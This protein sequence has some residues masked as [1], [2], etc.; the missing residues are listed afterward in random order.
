MNTIPIAFLQEDFHSEVLDFL[1]ELVSKNYPNTQLIWYNNVDRYDNI[2][3]YK[4]KYPNLIVK[5][6]DEFIPNLVDDVFHKCFIISYDNIINVNFLLKYVSKFIFIAHSPKHVELFNRLNL[7]Y[8]SLTP[9]LS[10]NFMLPILHECNP[11][12]TIS[13]R[14]TNQVNIEILDQ[15]KKQ[16]TEQNLIIVV[17]VGHFQNDNKDLNLINNLLSSK[18][19]L[20]LSFVP[21]ISPELQSLSEKNIGY[22]FVACNLSTSEIQFTINYLNIKYILFIPSFESK[23][24]KES[25][26]GSIAFAFDN[27]LN[28]IMP[29]MLSDYYNITSPTMI[30]YE[31][32]ETG[33]NIINT[34]QTRQNQNTLNNVDLQWVRNN[35]WLHNCQWLH[36]LLQ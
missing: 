2:S 17:T 20:L 35:V 21:Q 1:L 16:T 4:I 22:I 30:T 27:D 24:Y 14:L 5:S 8:F 10:N 34:L 31:Q 26:S 18:R 15:M 7:T 32:Q 9:L 19:I 13:N 23:F 33:A 28:L 11:K 3:L 12:Q 29:K 36:N 6:L 25:W